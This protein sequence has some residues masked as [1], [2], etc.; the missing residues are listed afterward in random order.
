[1]PLSVQEPYNK[2][3]IYSVV[4]AGLFQLKNPFIGGEFTR[5]VPHG[6]C[7]A[8]CCRPLSAKEPDYTRAF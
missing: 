4:F 1:M 5:G 2:R 3:A 8:V 7:V 6:M